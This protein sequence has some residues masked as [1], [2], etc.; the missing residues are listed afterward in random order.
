MSFTFKAKNRAQRSWNAAIR[1][2]QDHPLT[3]G[4]KKSLRVA[5]E[6]PI[7]NNPGRPKGFSPKKASGKEPQ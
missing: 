5:L 6:G 1:F 4:E 2:G 3:E 7:S